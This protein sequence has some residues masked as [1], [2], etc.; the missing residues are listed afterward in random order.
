MPDRLLF[1]RGRPAIVV[2]FL[3]LILGLTVVTSVSAQTN[4]VEAAPTVAELKARVDA[5]K[6][7]VDDL[8]REL[9]ERAA[10]R[11]APPEAWKALSSVGGLLVICWA[12]VSGLRES[13]RRKEAILTAVV[14]LREKEPQEKVNQEFVVRAINPGSRARPASPAERATPAIQACT[15]LP[16]LHPVSL[17]AQS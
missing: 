13:T 1:P 4:P 9:G 7:E 8:K 3:V 14:K 15:P 12:I 2:S 17:P 10:V 5:L 16:G 11:P 6:S